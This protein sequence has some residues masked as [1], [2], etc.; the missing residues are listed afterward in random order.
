RQLSLLVGEQASIS[1][2][3]VKSYSE[4]VPGI[5][6]LRLPKEGDQ[7]VLLARAPGSTTLLLFMLDG[8]EV[9]YRIE[10]RPELSEAPTAI[11]VAAE[12]NIRLDLYF[13]QLSEGYGHNLG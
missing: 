10:V 2:L 7:F 13:V 5:V 12:D 1:A 8:R 6:E 4:G 9:H 3:G 11:S